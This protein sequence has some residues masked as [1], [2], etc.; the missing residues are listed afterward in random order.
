MKISLFFLFVFVNGLVIALYRTSLKLISI[1]RFLWL[2]LIWGI[3]FI[4]G[5]I[6]YFL[7]NGTIQNIVFDKKSILGILLWGMTFWLSGY[8]IMT[9]LRQGFDISTFSASY[10]IA[11]VICIVAIGILFFWEK[12]NTLQV[13][14]LIFWMGSI[15]LLSK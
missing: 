1:D 5:I 8:L 6:L 15:Y 10:A 9:W 7:N 13:V 4:I 3:V 2:A 14:W 11:S 12:I